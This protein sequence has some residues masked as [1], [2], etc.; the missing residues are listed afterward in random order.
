MFPRPDWAE[1]K[2]ENHSR[3]NRPFWASSRGTAESFQNYYGGDIVRVYH[4]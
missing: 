2:V 4:D 3:G 1:F